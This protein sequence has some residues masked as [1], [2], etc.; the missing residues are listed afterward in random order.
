MEI[1]YDYYRIFY[2]VAKYQSFTKAAHAL[3]GNQ[4]NITRTI[5]NL[6]H[7]L[8]CTLFSRSGRTTE[9]T[10]EGEK[11]FSH[12]SAAFEHIEAAEREIALDR[13][14][15]SGIVTVSASETALHCF[16]LPILRKYRQLYPGVHIQVMTSS[17]PGSIAAL[18]NGFADLSLVSSPMNG[19]SGL[20]MFEVKTFQDVAV[21]GDAFSHLSQKPL[22]LEELAQ[23][24]IISLEKSTMSYSLYHELFDKAGVAFTP[25]VDVASANQIVPMAAYDL[26]IGFVP[27]PFLKGAEHVHIL[28]LK[29]PLPLRKICMLKRQGHPISIAS[30]ELEHLILTYGE[31]NESL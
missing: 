31:K 16:L 14:L 22:S 30:K 11:L 28:T 23:Y 19:T 3:N 18:K 2:Y 1:S 25:S 15:Q 24:P 4:P 9:L 6:E 29:E 8:G 13:S 20:K 17:T 21:C 5:K 10:P 12:I 26:G 7:A 27:K